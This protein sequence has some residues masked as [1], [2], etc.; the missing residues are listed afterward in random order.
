MQTF[1]RTTSRATHVSGVDIPEDAKV[2]LFLA[3]ANRDPRRWNEPDRYDVTR[4]TGG[5]V[6]FGWGI[7]RCVGEMLARLEGEA[8]LTAIARR[9]RRIRPIG[10]PRV[11]LNNTIRSYDRL[12]LAFDA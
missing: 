8:L 6:G 7:H 10:A 11:R 12:P 9:V 3:S 5:H 4:R 2:L 1:F